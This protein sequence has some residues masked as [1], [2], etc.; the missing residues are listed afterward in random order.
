[1]TRSHRAADRSLEAVVDAKAGTTISVCI[2]AR[3]ESATIGPIVAG[4]RRSLVEQAPLVDQVLVADDGSTDET[5]T[6]ARD[7]GA[8]IVSV[9]DT[10]PALDPRPGKGEA[11]WT[12]LA[13]ST[14]DLVVW[15]DADLERFDPRW[16]AR[17]V[18]PL[19]FDS[20]VSLVKGYYERVSASLAGG[21]GR[22]TELVARPVLSMFHPHLS[23]I[24]QPLGGEYA[25]RRSS[26]ENVPFAGG[27]G[28]DLG[29]IIDVSR[30]EGIAAIAQ[31]DLGQRLHRNRPVAE[32]AIQAAEVLHVALRR[33]GVAIDSAPTLFPTSPSP[34]TYETRDRP[35]LISHLGSSRVGEPEP[36]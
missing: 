16:V 3:N 32:L 7:A 34:A 8:E 19:L 30:R 21:G 6:R 27:Y 13:A 14:G 29:L 10:V 2:P 5:A 25:A 22:V 12:A 35:P 26:L 33:A 18:A 17:L 31:V 9:A 28:V 15:I 4:L 36:T 11:M 23:P 1:M 24:L 20:R